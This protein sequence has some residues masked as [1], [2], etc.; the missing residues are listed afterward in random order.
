VASTVLF[1]FMKSKKNCSITGMTT[2]ENL[3]L[4]LN[5]TLVS[6]ELEWEISAVVTLEGSREYV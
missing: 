3:S 2:G 6:S 1:K 4:K 5:L